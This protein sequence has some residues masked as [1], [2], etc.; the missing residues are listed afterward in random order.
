[1]EENMQNNENQANVNV[2]PQGGEQTGKGQAI[3]CLV[4]GIVSVICWFFGWSA[5][6]SV[7]LGLIRI[8]MMY[9]I[10]LY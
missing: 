4:C 2:T 8:L 6:A 10:V 1:M 5:L 7:V 3:A 9:Q